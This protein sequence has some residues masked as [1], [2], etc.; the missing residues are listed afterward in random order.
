VVGRLAGITPEGALCLVGEDGAS[1]L[2]ES[3]DVSLRLVENE[4]GI[5]R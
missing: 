4:P 5:Q 2:V 1:Q 3:G